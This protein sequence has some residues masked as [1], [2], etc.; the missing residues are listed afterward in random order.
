MTLDQWSVETCL[1]TPRFHAGVTRVGS[2]VFIMG[3]FLDDD[4]FDRA[5]GVTGM[6]SRRGY[7]STSPLLTDCY[8]LHKG[9]WS[10]GAEHPTDVW[11]H[12]CVALNVPVCRDDPPVMEA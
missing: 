9:V 10:K 1:P 6:R 4:M 7:R 11:E 5:T 3:G 12:A 8:D 2:M